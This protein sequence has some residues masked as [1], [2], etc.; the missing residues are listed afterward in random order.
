[1]KRKDFS[2]DDAKKWIGKRVVKT[3]ENN[4][5]PKPFKSQRKINTVKDVIEHPI[6]KTPAFTF[7]EDDSYVSCLV[8]KLYEETV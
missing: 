1:M 7:V 4:R 2:Y 5:T 6:L 8:C 3:R